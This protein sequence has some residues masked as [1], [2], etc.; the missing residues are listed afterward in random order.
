MLDIKMT[1]E[2]LSYLSKKVIDEQNK[3]W[4]YKKSC[5]LGP[6]AIILCIY[7]PLI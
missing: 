3:S 1:M 7:L 5:S 2:N 6:T 4:V